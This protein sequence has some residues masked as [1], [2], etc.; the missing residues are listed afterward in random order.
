MFGMASHFVSPTVTFGVGLGDSIP[1][2]LHS[3]AFGRSARCAWK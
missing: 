1:V 3:G 2:H